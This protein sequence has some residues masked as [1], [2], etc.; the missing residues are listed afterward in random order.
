MFESDTEHRLFLR[1]LHR[2]IEN[3]RKRVNLQE[4]NCQEGIP[5]EEKDLELMHL[6]LRA[7]EVSLRL[8]KLDSELNQWRNELEKGTQW[9]ARF[10]QLVSEKEQLR[11]E[12]YMFKKRADELE[13][14]AS[15]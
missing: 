9:Y 4:F 7:L 2:D 11:E 3:S 14:Q 12:I 15:N 5:W 1:E 13:A 6:T 8:R 10:D